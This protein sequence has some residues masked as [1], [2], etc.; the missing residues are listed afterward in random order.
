MHI[1]GE[2]PTGCTVI[3]LALICCWE[4]EGGGGGG[5]TEVG[6]TS[7]SSAFAFSYLEFVFTY[8]TCAFYLF[9]CILH[10]TRFDRFLIGFIVVGVLG[11]SVGWG[12]GGGV[13]TQI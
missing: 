13:V 7:S 4:G 6:G 10:K 2:Q 3:H 12:G 5:L 8:L 11:R 9:V 1:R